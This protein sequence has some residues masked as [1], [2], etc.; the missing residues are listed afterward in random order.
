LFGL[1]ILAYLGLLAP[2]KRD[3]LTVGALAGAYALPW[4]L[5]PVNA[6]ARGWL[7]LVVCAAYWCAA[8]ALVPRCRAALHEAWL[9]LRAA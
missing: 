5:V 1:L 2:L 4:T 8:A 3:L 6:D 9:S 7:P